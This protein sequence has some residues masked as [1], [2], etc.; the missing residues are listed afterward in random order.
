MTNCVTAPRGTPSLTASSGALVYA[1]PMVNSPSAHL[2]SATLPGA[3]CGSSAHAAVGVK[4]RAAAV[5]RIWS[6]HARRFIATPGLET[7]IAGIAHRG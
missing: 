2:S 7:L 5:K 3:G 6:T 4:A 1:G